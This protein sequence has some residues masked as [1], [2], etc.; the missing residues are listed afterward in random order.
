VSKSK[1]ILEQGFMEPNLYT[2]VKLVNRFVPEIGTIL[3]REEAQ[4]LLSASEG[5][6]VEVLPN[7]RHKER[8]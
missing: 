8:H 4:S 3:K 6:T 5:L 7:K 2:V 1:L